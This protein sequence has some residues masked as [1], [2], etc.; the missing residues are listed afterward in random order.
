MPNTKNAL[1]RQQVLDSLLRTERGYST[2]EMADACNHKLDMLGLSRVTALNTIRDDIRAIES[3][4]HTLVEV[5]KIG[6]NKRYR[7]EDRNFSIYKAE[8]TENELQQLNQTLLMLSRFEGR[9]NFEW[10]QDF[11]LRCQAISNYSIDSKPII[12][13]DENL[14][15][16]GMHHLRPLFEA[17]SKKQTLTLRYQSFN[18]VE[19]KNFVVSPYY[20]KEYNHRW[21]LIAQEEGRTNFSNFALD[22]IISIDFSS[23]P[24]VETD[25]DFFDYFFDM[26]GVSKPRNAQVESV[27]L[28]VAKERYPYVKTKPIHGTQQV[29][30][31][32]ETGTVIKIDVIIN[33]E[34]E[35]R[36]LSFGNE[37]KVIE[38]ASLKEKIQC[39]VGDLA[40]LY[41]LPQLD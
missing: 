3:S 7:Y 13:Y 32:D 5:V 21:F 23:A 8:M 16:E 10:I 34:L 28:W 30:S 35:Q 41:G 26:I 9:K 2:Q 4:Y 1:V 15:L 27:V 6:R 40:K 19:P 36:I 20:L 37:M 24:Y 17:I 18:S 38:P 29:V 31:E 14:D 22:R 25:E 11:N 39:I 33:R 12:G